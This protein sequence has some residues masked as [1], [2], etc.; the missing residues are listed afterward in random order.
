MS[1]E[2]TELGEGGRWPGEQGE[3]A[4]Q[5]EK[6]DGLGIQ[7]GRGLVEMR[8]LGREMRERKQETGVWR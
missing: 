5:N 6:S 7:A 8:G 3:R 1:A 4:E 2:T